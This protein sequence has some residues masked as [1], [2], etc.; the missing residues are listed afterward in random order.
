MALIAGSIREY[1]RTIPCLVDPDGGIIAG[2]GRSLAAHKL[3][4]AEVPVMIAAGWSE[5]KKRAYILADNQLAL[6]AGWD[7][8]LL[9]SEL[10]DSPGAHRS[11]LAGV[12]GR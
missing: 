1:G 10:Q 11:L 7:T 12:L 6:N 5:A 2:H 9:G 4:I 3:G 8:A